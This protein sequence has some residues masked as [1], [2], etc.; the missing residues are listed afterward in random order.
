MLFSPTAHSGSDVE[1]GMIG[2]SLL[3]GSRL[4]ESLTM[5]PQASTAGSIAKLQQ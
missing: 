2:G 4:V 1:L 5:M 3:T